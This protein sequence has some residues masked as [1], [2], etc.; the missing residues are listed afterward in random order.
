MAIAIVEISVPGVTG[1]SAEVRLYARGTDL[2]AATIAL[3]EETNRKCVYRGTTSSGLS[4]TYYAQ[5]LIGTSVYADGWVEM[6][7]EATVHVVG[8]NVPGYQILEAVG[9]ISSGVEVNFSVSANSPDIQTVDA[10]GTR[11]TIVKG[12]YTSFTLTIGS[13]SGR[14]GEKLIATFKR[15]PT[16]DDADAVFQVTESSGL[17]VLNG[18]G[19]EDAGGSFLSSDASMTVT[20][21]SAGTVTFV[22]KSVL[23]NSLDVTTASPLCWDVRMIRSDSQPQTKTSP[24]ACVISNPVTERTS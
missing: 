13:V 24:G 23:T 10:T 15:R 9:D 22:L 4:G 16:D 12:S 21:E 3:T 20:D 1:A 17:V 18:V 14:T 7:D 5:F 19:I 11:I 2:L 6:T 8:D